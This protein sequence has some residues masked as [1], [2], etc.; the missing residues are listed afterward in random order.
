M[1]PVYTHI[2]RRIGAVWF[3]SKVAADL[4][5]IFNESYDEWKL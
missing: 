2:V 1:Q 4:L 5:W 3:K